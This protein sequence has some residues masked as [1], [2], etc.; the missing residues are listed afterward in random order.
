M[1]ET[2]EIKEDAR[3]ALP[4]PHLDLPVGFVSLKLFAELE[5][6]HIEVDRPIAIFGRHS[7]AE[8]R[9]VFAEV[10]R[11]HC[12]FTFEN[13]Q[14]RICDLHSLNGI[15]LNGQRVTEATLYAGDRLQIGCVKLLVESATTVRGGDDK[16]RQIADALP[17]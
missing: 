9:F 3:H 17:R 2:R 4:G 12:R 16:L 11:R 10:S 13:G 7:G 8:L 6:V 5:R 15:I 1:H 14:W